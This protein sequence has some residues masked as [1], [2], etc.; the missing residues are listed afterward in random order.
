VA[1]VFVAFLGHICWTALSHIEWRSGPPTGMTGMIDVYPSFL[2]ARKVNKTNA[3]MASKRS[4]IAG[5][6]KRRK[7]NVGDVGWIAG[8]VYLSC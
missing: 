6:E 4:Y 5:A 7:K 8:G 3:V 2:L 1:G